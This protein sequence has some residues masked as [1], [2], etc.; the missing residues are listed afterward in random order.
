MTHA[1]RSLRLV[2][3][4]LRLEQ[5]QM[6]E[7]IEVLLASFALTKLINKEAEPT[8]SSDVCPIEYHLTT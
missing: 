2:E 1:H 3:E 4:D 8:C 5:Q 7:E 6:R